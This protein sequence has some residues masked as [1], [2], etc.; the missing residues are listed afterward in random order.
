MFEGIPNKKIEEAIALEINRCNGYATT[1]NDTI[2][3][4]EGPTH[5]GPVIFQKEIESAVDDVLA[6]LES[7]EIE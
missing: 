6:L 7:G 2:T 4:I 3:S 5:P 1:L